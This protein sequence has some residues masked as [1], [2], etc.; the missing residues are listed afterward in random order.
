MH[1]LPLEHQPHPAVPI[2]STSAV[3][4]VQPG[5]QVPCATR[6]PEQLDPAAT[7]APSHHWQTVST[8]HE[9]QFVSAPQ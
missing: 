4:D 2:Q 9:P 1:A 7:Q 8:V 6:E 3:I 5:Q